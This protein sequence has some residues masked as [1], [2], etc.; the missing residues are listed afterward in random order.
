MKK[1]SIMLSSNA[2]AL[3]FVLNTI[4]VSYHNS[5]DCPA[6]VTGYRFASNI[7]EEYQLKDGEIRPV[8]IIF[9]LCLISSVGRF[10]I[11]SYLP[12]LPSIILV[13]VKYLFLVW[14]F[15]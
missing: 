15:S 1:Q 8:F 5:R 2:L 14:V 7:S 4:C 12:S 13:G 11:D 6:I 9:L 3:L 10:V